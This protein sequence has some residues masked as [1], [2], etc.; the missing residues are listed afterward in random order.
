MHIQ[1]AP[2]LPIRRLL[3]GTLTGALA[4]A[5]CS[6]EPGYEDAD[7]V[8]AGR[9]AA[10]APA[11][12]PPRPIASTGLG[13]DD[14]AAGER[15]DDG[16][17]AI[18]AAVLPMVIRTGHAEITVDSIEAALARLRALAADAGGFVGNVSVA[19][20]AE[21]RR[22]ASMELKIPTERFDGLVTGL[23]GV[24]ELDAFHVQA[25]DV[26]E[27]FVDVEARLANARRLEERLLG[28]MDRSG[29]KLADLLSVER[30]LAR[31]RE[32]A[33]RLEGRVRYLRTR[34]DMATLV[35]SL[36]EPG[37]IIGEY[38]GHKPLR[39]AFLRAWRNFIGF[40]AAIIAASGMLVPAALLL[41]GLAVLTAR[42]YDRFI[43]AA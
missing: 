19:G 13:R 9:E 27:E 6:T 12:A 28:L 7:V 17:Q 43:R 31:V 37:A 15:A 41:G 32:Q 35:V 38:A 18:G 42:L 21:Q 36:R 3:I 33:E 23:S 26:G 16:A 29:S 24:G 14:H 11:S 10:A 8:E 30:E 1:S 20:G 2:A 22:T 40:L 34:A 25:E 39:A 4:L 5:G